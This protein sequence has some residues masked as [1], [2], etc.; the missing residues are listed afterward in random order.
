MATI[1]AGDDVVLW[2]EDRPRRILRVRDGTHRVPG[3]GVVNLSSLVGQE[4]GSTLRLGDVQYR[5]LAPRLPDRLALL[6]RG[7]Q[8][9]LPKDASRIVFECGLNAG[10]RVL[11]AGVG[12]GAL[13][14]ALAHAVAPNGRVYAYDNREDHLRH[15]KANV[16][17]AGLDPVVEFR[18]GDVTKRIEERGLDAVVLDL[19]EPDAVVPHAHAA[20]A[21]SGVFAAYSPLVV[22]VERTVQALRSAGFVAVRALELLERGWTVHDRGSRPDTN[23]LAHTGFLVFGRRP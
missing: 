1:R 15:G 22:Q 14:L 17:A 18:V 12:S 2:S 13:T 19:P 7:A 3:L 9:V 4:W 23:M 20:L 6:E 21:P 8:I 11:E 10:A 5:L 16:A